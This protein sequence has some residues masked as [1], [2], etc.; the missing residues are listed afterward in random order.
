MNLNN[1]NNILLLKKAIYAEQLFQYS[2]MCE[3]YQVLA[4]FAQERSSMS[5]E[6]IE[7]KYSKPLSQ[8]LVSN[9]IEKTLQELSSARKFDVENTN[10]SSIYTD[11]EIQCFREFAKISKVFKCY[12]QASNIVDDTIQSETDADREKSISKFHKYMSHSNRPKTVQN[13]DKFIKTHSF[14]YIGSR[15]FLVANAGINR[16]NEIDYSHIPFDRLVVNQNMTPEKF[17]AI[18]NGYQSIR[19]QIEDIEQEQKYDHTSSFDP[20]NWDLHNL[21]DEKV[22]EARDEYSTLGHSFKEKSFVF[23][24]KV[25]NSVSPVY[26]AHKGTLKKALL[27]ALAVGSLIGGAHQVDKEIKASHL[28]LNSS[29]QYEQTVTDETK[30]YIN[31]II[32]ELNLQKSAFDP[33]YEDVKNIEQNIDLVLDYVVKDQVTSAFEAYHEGYKVT[34]VESWFDTSLSGTANSPQ[35]Y[36]FIDVS[37]IDDKGNEGKETISDFRSELLTH[38]SL[39]DVFEIEENIDLNSPVYSAFHDD[40]TKN[41]T[42][43]YKDLNSV[44]EYLTEMTQALQKRITPFSLE[45]GHSILGE[46]Y[47]KTTL[48]NEKSSEENQNIITN[49]DDAR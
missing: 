34:D 15:Y 26:K 31:N 30:T 10:I 12:Q 18:L 19:D 3:V 29:T 41:F 6:A 28:D 35:D 32:K 22:N 13:F 1:D 37:Y 9:D 42:T 43:K 45:H 39:N 33:Q 27:I 23:G 48:P 25:K 44:M 49:D 20:N 16:I 7:K 17:G 21:T 40:G 8:I 47:L 38:N 24:S 5:P 36:R 2:K 46:P 14:R 11:R 4:N